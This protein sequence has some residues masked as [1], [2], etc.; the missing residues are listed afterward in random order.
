METLTV[1]EASAFTGL[2]A[3]T[4]RYYERIGLLLPV[5]RNAGG[6]RRYAQTDLEHLRFLHCLRDTGMSIQRMQQYAALLPQGRASLEARLELLETH[7]QDVRA[8]IQELE[9]K[10]AIIDAKIDRFKQGMAQA[11]NQA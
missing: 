3:H 7:K 4:L 10:L 2:S 6:H 11:V 9:D 5:S 1:R 8:H